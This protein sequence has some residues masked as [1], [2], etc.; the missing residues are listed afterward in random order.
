[1]SNKLFV[2]GISWDTTD[3]S[4]RDAF[5]ACGEVLEAKVITDRETGRSRGFAFVTMSDSEGATRAIETL[6]GAAVDGRN[7]R[8]G[9]AQERS[10][11]GGGGER[12][13]Y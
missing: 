12:R 10:R 6:D 13:R 4:L 9:I 7:V 5:E 1:M 2:G 11:G 3:R 8:V